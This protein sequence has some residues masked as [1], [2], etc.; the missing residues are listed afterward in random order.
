MGLVLSPTRELEFIERRPC[1]DPNRIIVLFLDRIAPLAHAGREL[2]RVQTQVELCDAVEMA[3]GWSFLLHDL[4][5]GEIENVP[6]HD[7]PF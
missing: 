5:S 1:H 7:I 2:G 6:A 4:P 3:A